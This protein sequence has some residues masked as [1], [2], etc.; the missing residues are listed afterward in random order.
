MDLVDTTDEILVGIR[1]LV[2]A[3]RLIPTNKDF[4]MAI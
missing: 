2:I 1:E 4:L 3:K